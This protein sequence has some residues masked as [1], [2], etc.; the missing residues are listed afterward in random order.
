MIKGYYVIKKNSQRK[1]NIGRITEEG[2][3]GSL[4]KIFL[5]PKTVLVFK[6]HQS[7]FLFLVRWSFQSFHAWVEV[8]VDGCVWIFNRNSCGMTRRDGPISCTCSSLPE[9][10]ALTISRQNSRVFQDL[11][12]QSP[13]LES[14]IVSLFICK[15]YRGKT[16][17]NTFSKNV[18]PS[19]L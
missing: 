7:C 8:G 19:T 12:T 1:R 10:W 6:C 11:F 4:G 5:L 17:K 18:R 15:A 2:G 13:L 3:C 9:P 14:S 16:Y